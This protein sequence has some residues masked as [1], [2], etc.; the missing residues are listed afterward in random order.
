MKLACA[1]APSL[2]QTVSH[3]PPIKLT[4]PHHSRGLRCGLRIQ[5]LLE[6]DLFGSFNALR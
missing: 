4:P 6:W 3:P 1:D 2:L 5:I